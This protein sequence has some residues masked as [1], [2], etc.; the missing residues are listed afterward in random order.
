M[1]VDL[2]N[3]DAPN[4]G[5]DKNTYSTK[6]DEAFDAIRNHDHSHTNDRGLAVEIPAKSIVTAK[7]AFA[8]VTATQ[9]AAISGNGGV[10]T[11]ILSL[12]VPAL[13][14]G[15]LLIVSV[16]PLVSTGSQS[17]LRAL[18][19]L[20][21]LSHG[22]A[23]TRTQLDTATPLTQGCTWPTWIIPITVDG[24]ET[25]TLLADPGAVGVDPKGISELIRLT[26]VVLGTA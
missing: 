2:E 17:Y 22:T 14:S 23:L 15:N 9:S 26:A 21:T 1:A 12:N 20:T 13:K 4:I 5:D 16:N 24:A 6:I 7:Q 25:L 18:V 19:K 10:Y 11:T 3:I 8:T